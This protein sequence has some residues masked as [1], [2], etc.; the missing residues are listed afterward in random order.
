MWEQFV[1][2]ADAPNDLEASVLAELRLDCEA[3]R[4]V[5]RAAL[6]RLHAP[7]QVDPAAQRRVLDRFRRQRGLWRRADLDAWLTANAL[8]A[9]ALEHLLCREATLDA[10]AASRKIDAPVCHARSPAAERAVL[11]LLQMV[12]TKQ[13]ALTDAPPPPLEPHR[14]AV[15]DWYF[16]HRLGLMR[17]PSLAAF[18]TEAGWAG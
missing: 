13:A 5:Q 12:R 4:D 17:P 1:A 18:L 8:D 6:G 3:W 14:Q 16:E 15:L 7:R 11:V 9:A 10:E 2:A